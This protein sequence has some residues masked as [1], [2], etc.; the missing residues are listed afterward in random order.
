M[1][2]PKRIQYRR[3]QPLPPNTKYVG[4]PTKWG[5]PY[6][7]QDYGREEAL[8]LYAEYLEEKL[9]EDPEFIEPLRGYD[10]DC[11]CPLSEECH[12][13]ILIELFTPLLELRKNL[14]FQTE[15]VYFYLVR[16]WVSTF[17]KDEGKNECFIHEEKFKGN[18]L[19][20]CKQE[21]ENYYYHRLQG[22]EREGATYF[23]P[24]AGPK[25]FIEGK[26]AAFS[27]HLHLVEYYNEDNLVE[28]ILIGEDDQTN[29]EGRFIEAAVL[30]EKGFL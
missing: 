30:R 17:E 12:A 6:K 9:E 16:E 22:L 24:F 1:Q 3:G 18:N 29:A 20:K 28:H 10:L 27:I 23:L 5:N 25:D 14:G 21:A 13:D 11:Y 7:V 15:P 4:R 2:N 26:N 19:L 8:R